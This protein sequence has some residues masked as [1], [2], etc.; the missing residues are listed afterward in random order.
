[1]DDLQYNCD[2]YIVTLQTDVK[3]YNYK[4]RVASKAS[5]DMDLIS[6]RKFQIH[7]KLYNYKSRF[8]NNI[9]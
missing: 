1:M 4:S 8:F 5:S 3:M 2:H 6:R 9:L 7:M